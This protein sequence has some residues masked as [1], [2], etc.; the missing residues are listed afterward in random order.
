MTPRRG[1]PQRPRAGSRRRCSSCP[2]RDERRVD[3]HVSLASSLRSLG[4]LDRCCATLL[5]AIELLPADAV[6][7]RV[8]LT[9]QCAAVE[10]WLGRH[11]EAHRRLTRA[12]EDLPDRST[13]D[14]AVLEIELAVDGLYERDFEQAVEMGRQALR[15]CTGGGQRS[16]D[17]IGRVGTVPRRDGRG[18]DPGCPRA[19]TGGT[20]RTRPSSGRRARAPARGPVLPRVGRELPRV[21]RRRR[22]PYRAGSRHSQSVRRGSAARAAA[23]REK[24]FL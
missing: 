13:A 4:Q 18:R 10:H 12:W 7:K 15:D 8:G 21:L 5:A 23:T 11:E 9:A 17:R 16:A 20:G 14:A 19:P 6:S 2:Q 22:R 24:L 3:V 1:R